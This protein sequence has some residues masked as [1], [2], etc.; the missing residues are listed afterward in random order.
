MGFKIVRVG[1]I[2]FHENCIGL[3]KNKLPVG[4]KL[5]RIVNLRFKIEC[6]SIFCVGRLV[7]AAIICRKFGIGICNNAEAHRCSVDGINDILLGC[8]IRN[9][10]F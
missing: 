10:V 1:D 3:T 5:C 4:C 6:N 7:C 8:N 9:I 2:R